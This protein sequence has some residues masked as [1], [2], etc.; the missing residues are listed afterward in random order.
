MKKKN[1]IDLVISKTGL[2]QASIA[3]ELGVSRAQISKWK[4]GEPIPFDRS[5]ALS[6]LAGMF[7]DDIQWLELVENQ[8]N[9]DA[10]IKYISD[11]NERSDR[12]VVELT[13]MSD[14]YVPKILKELNEAGINLPSCPPVL[15]DEESDYDGELGLSDLLFDF[16]EHY[17]IYENWSNCHLMDLVQYVDNNLQSE[18]Y[19]ITAEIN[20]FASAMAISCISTDHLSAVNGD[21]NKFRTF[22][23]KA[24]DGCKYQIGH[25]CKKLVSNSIPLTINYYDFVNES[26]YDL[27]DKDM[28]ADIIKEKWILQHLPYGEQDIIGRMERVEEG[29]VALHEKIDILLKKLP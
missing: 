21:K 16:L 19:E 17:H 10:W 7:T 5:E 14:Y 27:E 25:L 24:E 13:D 8:K 11:I 28:F 2:N 15:K 3:K 26:P 23:K 9:A 18:V 20:H 1:L 4:T 29:I 22:I 12:P 6:K